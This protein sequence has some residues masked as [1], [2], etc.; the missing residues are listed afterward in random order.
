MARRRRSRRHE[1]RASGLMSR[2]SK[3]VQP[4]AFGI[5]F[6][7]QMLSKDLPNLPS[8]L[9]NTQKLQAIGSL[10]V[11]HLTGFTPMPQYG[12]PGITLNLTGWANKYTAMGVGLAVLSEVV[13]SKYIGKKST[14]GNLAK[15]LIKGGVI[16]GF[17]DPGSGSRGG[18]SERGSGGLSAIGARTGGAGARGGAY[19]GSNM[20]Y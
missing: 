12:S 8:N 20:G 13:P 18:S 2:A 9:S 4:A 10:T 14:I 7:G 11:S 3:L 17:L 6:L 16:G 15:G 19:L 5:S 1:K